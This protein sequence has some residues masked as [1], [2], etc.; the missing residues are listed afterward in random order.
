M[1]Q[2]EIWWKQT[3]NGEKHSLLLTRLLRTKRLACFPKTATWPAW[4]INSI[5]KIWT[6]YS[7]RTPAQQLQE[8]YENLTWL[9]A[10]SDQS[11]P[12]VSI[13]LQLPSLLRHVAADHNIVVGPFQPCIIWRNHVRTADSCQYIANTHRHYW[14]WEV[15]AWCRCSSHG[16]LDYVHSLSLSFSVCD[17][18]ILKELN[19]TRVFLFKN[20]PQS[21]WSGQLLHC[22]LWLRHWLHCIV[23]REVRSEDPHN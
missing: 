11:I 22:S 4:W 8:S 14:D 1:L 19:V 13:A 3:K 16:A 21:S 9:G 20:V 7:S 23:V 5:W 2:Q 17:L 6:Y 10:F 12:L 15:T 18:Y